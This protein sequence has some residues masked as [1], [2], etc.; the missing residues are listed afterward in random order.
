[1]ADDPV[2]SVRSL[3]AAAGIAGRRVR[4]V[5]ALLI[6]EAHTVASLVT[7]SGVDR[8]TVEA[9]LSALEPDLVT[10]AHA[11]VRIA[12][13]R[14]QTYRELA[15]S[16]RPDG[17]RWLPYGHL[18]A[19][20]GD[21]VARL[22]ELV[23]TA[24]AAR[25]GLDHV[26]ATARTIALRALWLDATFE[27]AG[28]TV[29]CV[30]DHDL[31]SLALHAVNPEVAVAVVDIDDGV[32]EHIDTRSGGAIRC[33]WGDLRF[34]LP[35]GLQ[36]GADLVVT[37]PPY[38]PDG[39]RLF[40]TRGLQGLRARDDGRA[41]PWVGGDAARLVMAYGFGEQPA[42]GVK[43]QQAV[44]DL[45]LAVEAI[46][47]DF[48]RYHGAQAV[49][50]S[51]DLYVLRP[52]ARSLRIATSPRQ[53]ASLGIYTHGGQ[54]LEGGAD[55][56]LGELADA[57]LSSAS[58]PRELPVG[59][60]VGPGWPRQSPVVGLAE[61]LAG[62]QPPAALGRP[63]AEQAVAVDLRADPGSWLVRVLLATSAARVAVL[64]PNSHP[65][66]TDERAQRALHELVAAKYR[67]RLRRS[68]PGPRLAI[69]E[70][71]RI[72]PADAPGLAVRGVLDRAHGKLANT[73]REALIAST[74]GRLTR[75]EARGRVRTRAGDDDRLLA[76][77]RH[78]LL[79][80]VAEIS[81]SAGEP[82]GPAS[83]S[84]PLGPASASE[85]TGPASASEPS[86][87]ASAGEV[88]TGG[89]NSRT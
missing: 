31:T 87:P 80:V 79:E 45:Q 85:P 2:D 34:G 39:V 10:G 35:D 70:A 4:L 12:P 77:P 89:S 8:R 9:V 41:Q 32:L 66:L 55:A 25:R 53:A 62:P 5:V 83:A 21:L 64:V 63:G 24:P 54:S 19:G 67:L 29:L 71:D 88:Q 27:L 20:H 81:A 52:T 49:G 58:G 75:N 13:S 1:M 59:A 73:W 78:R 50:S 7:A 46:L 74:G 84:E 30:G 16:V 14:A 11:K 65:D 37:D 40:L 72:E 36:G 60:V 76:L 68:T 15:G 47:P 6:D 26:S 42:L 17:W 33:V 28:A 23:A 82:T 48:N 86:G 61:L 43:V 57:L 38:T 18:L 44:T 56:A 51:S 3:I 69:V 22:A